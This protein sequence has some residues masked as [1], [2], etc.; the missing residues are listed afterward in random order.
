MWRIELLGALRA[1]GRERTINR[2]SAGKGRSL[3]A[4]LA[5]Y[6]DREHPREELIELLWPECEPSAGRLRLRVAVSSLRRQLEPPGVPSGAAIIAESDSLRLNPH[7]IE[8]DVREFEAALG[9]VPG[10]TPEQRTERLSHAVELHAAELLPGLYDDWVLVERDRLSDLRLRA[11]EELIRLETE[12]GRLDF[13][14]DYAR[15][16]VSTA[17]EREELQQ[18]LIRL[19][20]LLGR[21]REAKS[22]LRTLTRLLREQL[23]VE[24]RPGTLR[25]LDLEPLP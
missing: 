10:Q 1:V 12:S 11:L 3:L 4:R 17:P 19:L 20:V 14:L 25:L 6:L 9:S 5:F 8:T 21:K 22:Q 7:T 16:A 18:H 24:P 2:F 23:G 13:A 15:R